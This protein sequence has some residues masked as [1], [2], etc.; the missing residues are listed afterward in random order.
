[1]KKTAL[2]PVPERFLKA[3]IRNKHGA[4]CFCRVCHSDHIVNSTASELRDAQSGLKM[5][6]M[7]LGDVRQSQ[8][9]PACDVVKL[10]DNSKQIIDLLRENLRQVR[11][12]RAAIRREYTLSR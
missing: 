8:R 7:F 10:R 3:K 9:T 2:R 11:I 12:G 1:M 5:F 6:D 4:T